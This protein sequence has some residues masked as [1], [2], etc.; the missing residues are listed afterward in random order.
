MR[1]KAIVFML[2]SV[3]LVFLSSAI[4]TGATEDPA[5]ATGK[6]YALEE[7]P[8]SEC[9]ETIR[10]QLQSGQA[11]TECGGNPSDTVTYPVFKSSKP[12]YGV[13]PFGMSLFDPQAGRRYHFALDESAGAGYDR[14][15]FDA[16]GD[17]DLT[18]DPA[19][20]LAKD[21]PTDTQDPSG[22]V[23]FENVQVTFDYG[24]GAGTF[25]QTVIPRLRR[26]G[27]NIRMY[28]A[29]ST[30]R[31]GKI[32]LDSEELELVLGQIVSV[33]G[34]YDGPMTGAFLVGKDNS[35]PVIAY[36]RHV[37]GTFYRLSPTPAGDKVAVIPYSGPFGV[38]EAGVGNQDMTPT[39]EFGWLF[40][41][42]SLIDMSLCRRAGGKIHLPVGDYRPFRLA[43]R[44]GQRRI[45][46]AM[47]TSQLGQEN[48]APAVFPIAI[49]SDKPYVPDFSEKPNVVFKTPAAGDR[50]RA[51][52]T[53]SVQA[54]L[55]DVRTNT[56]I[57]AIEDTTKKTGSDKLPSGGEVDM[58]E[59]VAPMVRITNSS[60]RVVAE[61]AMPFG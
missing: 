33:S 6:T 60:G 7:I 2:T 19:V 57:S 15:Y 54:I 48:A 1:D 9:P 29:A 56:M 18:N 17:R 40:G 24:P 41:K 21:S 5:A 51:G 31:K 32:V 16:N 39:I 36:W 23:V 14:L 25:T 49:R 59:S 53:L 8:V 11:T 22:S 52:Q 50:V 10:S 44:C 47:D 3:T 26:S 58:F 35:L 27:E 55:C 34:R 4:L 38:L 46:M 13:V 28:F 12:V 43:V 42:D 45:G 30:A 20:G 61:G 37:D